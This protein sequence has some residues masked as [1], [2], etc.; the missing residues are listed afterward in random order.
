[1]QARS[2]DAFLSVPIKQSHQKYLRVPLAMEDL[3]VQCPPTRIGKSTSC[4]HKDSE[5]YISSPASKGIEV[6]GL[7]GRSPDHRQEPERNAAGISAHVQ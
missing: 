4:V 2:K 5:T 6:G 7:P 1:M 3:S